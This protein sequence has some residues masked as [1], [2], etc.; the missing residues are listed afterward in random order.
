[1]KAEMYKYKALD[2]VEDDLNEEHVK[3]LMIKG[4]FYYYI[5]LGQM[6]THRLQYRIFETRF[7]KLIRNEKD[8]NLILEV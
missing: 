4:K 2:I 6:K 1:M 3:I 5:N 8:F 7:T